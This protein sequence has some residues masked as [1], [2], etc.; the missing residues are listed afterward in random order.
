[1]TPESKSKLDQVRE[2]M[3]AVDRQ[4]V[5]RR[6]RASTDAALSANQ[7]EWN[8][9]QERL[10]EREGELAAAE[11]RVR[12]LRAGAVRAMDELLREAADDG[13]PF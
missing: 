3:L 13:I 9:L 12:E 7:A 11:Q 1:M 6:Q 10:K 2:Y 4:H 5:A 8:Q